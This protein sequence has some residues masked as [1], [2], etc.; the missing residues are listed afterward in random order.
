VILRVPKFVFVP[1]E[2]VN[3]KWTKRDDL[4]RFLEPEEAAQYLL[5][6]PT[7]SMR[8]GH[9]VFLQ[10][11]E[12]DESVLIDEYLRGVGTPEYYLTLRH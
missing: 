7:I 8:D 6:H 9:P 10:W 2:Y 4:P 3:G 5:D 1:F 12:R 11:Q